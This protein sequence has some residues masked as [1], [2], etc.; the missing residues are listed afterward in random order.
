MKLVLKNIFWF[1]FSISGLYLYFDYSNSQNDA[2]F[3]NFQNYKVQIKNNKRND[4][5]NNENHTMELKKWQDSSQF[6]YVTKNGNVWHAEKHYKNR[7]KRYRLGVVLSTPHLFSRYD[8]PCANC[9]SPLVDS[10]WLK[11]IPKQ[12]KM[13]TSI[14]EP[15]QPWFYI[16]WNKFFLGVLGFILL[17][18]SIFIY[19]LLKDLVLKDDKLEN[20]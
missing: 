19:Q 10:N 14:Y 1:T 5:L 18:W 13:F 7:T 11:R 8:V 2:F 3:N 16:R 15:E 12:E 20:N 6:V 17:F 9:N 4:S